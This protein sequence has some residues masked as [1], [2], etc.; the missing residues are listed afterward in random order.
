[1][2]NVHAIKFGSQENL[3]I[4]LNTPKPE[5]KKLDRNHLSFAMGNSSWN[6]VAD[7]M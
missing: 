5:K 1:M 3:A 2:F 6:I 4:H 7:M